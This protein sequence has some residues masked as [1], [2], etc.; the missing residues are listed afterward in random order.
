MRALQ[1]EYEEYRSWPKWY[2]HLTFDALEKGQLFNDD[3]EYA[4]GMNSVAI[5]QYIHNLSI[6]AFNLMIN[7]CHILLCGSGENMVKFFTFMKGRINDRLKKDGYPPLPKKYGFKAVRVEDKKRLADTI[8][9]IARNPVKAC[10]NVTPSSYPWG[11]TSMIFNGMK[12]F[13]EKEPL[14]V[15]S[16]S[17]ARSMLK[18]RVP[19]PDNY[20]FNRK[21]GFIL[22]ESYV[23][24]AKAE[25]TMGNSWNYSY[26]IIRNIDGYLRIAEGI[27]ETVTLS[28]DEL[29]DIISQTIKKTFNA[30]SIRDLSTD[31]KCRLAIILKNRYKVSIKRIA[32]KTGIDVETLK[33]L[34]E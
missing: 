2:Y 26:G 15:L 4:H 9:Y 23:L 31:D 5:G 29:N 32:R 34:L 8:I 11:S 27:G 20:L 13:Y 30:G 24:T 22:P 6:L 33:E 14:S 12:D 1:A 7:H 3:G 17:E 19:L 16:I 18:S 10:P 28:E 21:K 25:E